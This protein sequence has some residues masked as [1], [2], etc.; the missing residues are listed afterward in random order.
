MFHI[1]F[2]HRWKSVDMF[3]TQIIKH[4]RLDNIIF[5]NLFIFLIDENDSYNYA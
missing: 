3:Q 5:E 2:V 1:S 4:N